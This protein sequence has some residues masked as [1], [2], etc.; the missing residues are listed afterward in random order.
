MNGDDEIWRDVHHRSG[1]FSV[2]RTRRLGLIEEA[3]GVQATD[4]LQEAFEN[5]ARLPML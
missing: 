3:L 5:I 1:F 2:N 4:S